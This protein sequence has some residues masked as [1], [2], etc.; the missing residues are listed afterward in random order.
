MERV[1]AGAL[2]SKSVQMAFN[3]SVR[4]RESIFRFGEV[5]TILT[6]DPHN[7]AEELFSRYVRMETPAQ[8]DP[9]L[10]TA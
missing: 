4:I 5:R 3:E 8:H 6:T 1:R 7:I 10:A 2:D 9:H